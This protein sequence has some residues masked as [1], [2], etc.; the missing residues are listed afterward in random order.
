MTRTVPWIMPLLGLLGCGGNGVPTVE[1]PSAPR[2]VV[3]QSY[4]SPDGY[5]EYVAGDLPLLLLVPHGGGLR[6][7][8]LPDRTTGVLDA[9]ANTQDLGRRI[10]RVLFQRTGHHPHVVVCLLHRV[11]LD[12]NRE[13]VAAASDGRARA[14]W[15]WFHRFARSARDSIVRRAGSGL[16]IDLHGHG[17][18]VQRLELG[19]LMDGDD[20][21][22]PDAVLARP[23]YA[24]ASSVRELASR[25][26]GGLPELLRG[27]GA[28]GTLLEARGFPSVPSA[29][30]PDPGTEPYF[31]G[32]YN[33]AVYGSRDG[34]GVSGVQLEANFTGVRDTPTSREAF[35]VAL[36]AAL[37]EFFPRR[38]GVPL[39]AQRP[40]SPRPSSR[41]HPV[42]SGVSA[43]GLRSLITRVPSRTFPAI[44]MRRPI[45]RLAPRAERVE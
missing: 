30:Q 15:G 9:D 29:A 2:Y 44:R 18:A 39:L 1:S 26:P 21:G 45:G 43:V 31:N 24:A 7:A 42:G 16:T 14:A 12:C 34:G 8:A 41:L 11:K 17:H 10:A 20:L 6:P 25:A 37:V 23:E 36:A 35:A 40:Q 33:T 4:F 28:L 5:V 19:Y 32:G 27:S 22:L 13:E 3:G 38:V